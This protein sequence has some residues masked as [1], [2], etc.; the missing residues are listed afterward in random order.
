M[1]LMAENSGRNMFAS[2]Q[3]ELREIQRGIWDIRERL[4]REDKANAL[5][6]TPHPPGR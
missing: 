3:E 4:E 1:R 5:R 6:Q 2:I